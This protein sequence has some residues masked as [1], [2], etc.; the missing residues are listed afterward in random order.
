MPTNIG[1]SGEKYNTYI[2][3]L[4]ENA[5]IQDA[6]RVYHFGDEFDQ[7]RDSDNYVK[8]SIAGLLNNLE[9]SK[10]SSAPS[11]IPAGVN[12]NIYVLSGF[13]IQASSIVSGSNYPPV[14]AGD[15]NN[16][17]GY[18][19]VLRNVDPV[20]GLP[21]VFNTSNQIVPATVNDTRPPA[22]IIFQTYQMF[23]GIS[24]GVNNDFF[25][26]YYLPETR[27]FVPWVKL[28]DST[29]VN[30][31][32][33]SYYTIAQANNALSP[34]TFLE[35]EIDTDY[36]LTSNDANRIISLNKVGEAIVT[37]PSNI[38]DAI[39][40]GTIINIYNRSA[41]PLR[42]QGASGVD[43]RLAGTLPRFREASLRKR[44]L[45]EWVATGLDF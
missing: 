13:Y 22:N 33:S 12:L 1:P 26:R 20:S 8:K 31:I 11:Q 15:N 18:L 24:P 3:L 36:V 43:V 39:P 17:G 21:T 6:L 32:L 19:R 45:D 10:L 14:K 42:V 4:S 29:D 2:P 7:D 41:T 28:L 40:L 34:K 25:I 5:N 16:Y 9:R 23:G 35:R 30:D 44:A 27:A 38:Q 37:V